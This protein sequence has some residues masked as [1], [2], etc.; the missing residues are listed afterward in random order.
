MT[1]FI[2]G[3]GQVFNETIEETGGSYTPPKEF[4]TLDG[5]ADSI[6][7]DKLERNYNCTSVISGFMGK[8][9][10]TLA[11]Q[12]SKRIDYRRFSIRRNFIFDPNYR[13]IADAINKLEKCSSPIVDEAIKSFYR[14][15]WFTEMQKSLMKLFTTSRK[16]QQAT[17]LCIPRFISLRTDFRND[18]TDY[19]IQVIARGLAVVFYRDVNPLAID[20]WHIKDNNKIWEMTSR[21][22]NILK[23]AGDLDEQMKILM[24]FKNFVTCFTFHQMPKEDEEEYL[25]LWDEFR[26]KISDIEDVELKRREQKYKDCLVKSM[27]MLHSDYGVTQTK[28]CEELNLAW[29][30]V[31][32]WMNDY[33]KQ[34]EMKDGTEKVG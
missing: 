12:L 18:V 26:F 1:D 16:Q 5:F 20:P 32:D 17:F 4:I 15:D 13:A 27:W 33:R 29:K 34:E 8:G 22:M 21:R 6:L 31:S 10:S 30:T 28:L 7:K 3:L 24:K 19:W 23:I 9:K 25:K 14:Q 11:Y 2:K